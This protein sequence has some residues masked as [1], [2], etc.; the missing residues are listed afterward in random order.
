MRKV[1]GALTILLSVG[2]I[3][4]LIIDAIQGMINLSGQP[5]V[6]SSDMFSR[7][8]VSGIL[9]TLAIL[10][11]ILPIGIYYIRKPDKVT[12]TQNV[13]FWFHF[14]SITL[15]IIAALPFLGCLTRISCGGEGIGEMIILSL[16]SILA[17]TLFFIGAVFLIVSKFQSK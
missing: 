12:R 11:M 14:S 7:F 6:T 8:L 5:G 10:I 1:I 3:L 4:L 13:A 15:L 17:G 2:T 9:P 16:A